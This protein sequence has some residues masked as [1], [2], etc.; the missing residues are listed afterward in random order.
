ML[1]RRIWISRPAKGGRGEEKNGGGESGLTGQEELGVRMVINEELE[2]LCRCSQLIEEI[3]EDD[4]FRGV[5]GG[6]TL[7][8]HISHLYQRP[9]TRFRLSAPGAFADL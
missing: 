9:A 1:I 8:T 6:A 7:S 5:G 4:G 2:S 3:C